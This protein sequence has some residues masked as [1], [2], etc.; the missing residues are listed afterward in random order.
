MYVPP[1]ST[2]QSHAISRMFLLGNVVIHR[3]HH[4]FNCIVPLINLSSRQMGKNNPTN[5]TSL[6]N[7]VVH[8]GTGDINLSNYLEPVG[9]MPCDDLY[10]EVLVDNSYIPPPTR[11]SR[12]K[13]PPQLQTLPS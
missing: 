11:I 3:L 4:F 9:H 5:P 8:V 6:S 7:S 1:C 10:S 12:M 13:L 2:P